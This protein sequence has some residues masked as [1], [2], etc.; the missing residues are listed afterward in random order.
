MKAEIVTEQGKRKIKVGKL[1]MIIL[2][3]DEI[4]ALSVNGLAG[5]K[6]KLK[7]VADLS[8]KTDGDVVRAFDF[9]RHSVRRASYINRG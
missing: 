3:E 8:T 4:F 1:S 6:T 7:R 9:I 5:Y 2:T